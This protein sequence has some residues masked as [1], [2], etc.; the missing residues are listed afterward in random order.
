MVTCFIGVADRTI[1]RLEDASIGSVKFLENLPS[2]TTWGI[3]AA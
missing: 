1:R 3:M 2:T